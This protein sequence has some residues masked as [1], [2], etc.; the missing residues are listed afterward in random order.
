M[1]NHNKALT[2]YKAVGNSPSVS[3]LVGGFG[4]DR[5]PV[6]PGSYGLLYMRDDEDIEGFN[7]E[8]KVFIL[9]LG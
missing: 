7:N 9:K 2:P 3:F 1:V 6:A 5:W 4:Q 8:F